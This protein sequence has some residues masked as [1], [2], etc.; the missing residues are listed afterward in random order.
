VLLGRVGSLSTFK[1]EK[2]KFIFEEDLGTLL[3]GK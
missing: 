2:H 3:N 1:V